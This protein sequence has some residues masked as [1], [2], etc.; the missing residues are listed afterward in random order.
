MT[1][2]LA[3][4]SG[5]VLAHSP[6]LRQHRTA[7]DIG[8]QRR[9]RYS[10]GRDGSDAT[11]SC[12]CP[13]LGREPWT[14]G[15]SGLMRRK[16]SSTIVGGTSPH[17]LVLSMAGSWLRNATAKFVSPRDVGTVDPYHDRSKRGFLTNAAHPPHSYDRSVTVRDQQIIDPTIPLRIPW[18]EEKLTCGKPPLRL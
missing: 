14:Y 17:G 18:N 3:N 13:L 12:C 8:R 16:N 15:P 9:T 4:G 1:T 7:A 10:D 6:S 11:P 2:A 5:P